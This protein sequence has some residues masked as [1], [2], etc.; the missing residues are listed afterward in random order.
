MI[1]YGNEPFGRNAVL[2]VALPYTI[3]IDAAAVFD[4]AVEADPRPGTIRLLDHAHARQEGALLAGLRRAEE[5]PLFDETFPHGR[6]W[7]SN[8]SWSTYKTMSQIAT[9]Y[10]VDFPGQRVLVAFDGS[11]YRP[12][13][14]ARS[15]TSA[16]GSCE[17]Q[18]SV[19]VGRR[20]VWRAFL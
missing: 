15:P 16:C 7:G 8:A 3:S 19:D 13:H 18:Q 6:G 5:L 1:F 9:S 20:S 14:L 17:P 2:G 12:T 11:P 10:R 4:Q